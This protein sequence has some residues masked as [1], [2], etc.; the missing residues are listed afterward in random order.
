MAD[1]SWLQRVALSDD[2]SEAT[3]RA[4]RIRTITN[5]GEVGYY[6]QFTAKVTKQTGNSYTIAFSNML[7]QGYGGANSDADKMSGQMGIIIDGTRYTLQ[8]WDTTATSTSYRNG[9]W[10]SVAGLSGSKSGLTR[11]QVNSATIFV[12]NLGNTRW[13]G[14]NYMDI[15][16]TASPG[17]VMKALGS[18]VQI[19]NTKYYPVIGNGVGVDRYNIQIGSDKY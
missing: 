13:T 3:M 16:D 10:T 15:S 11:E 8:N 18:T 4:K 2:K 17:F 6:F 14:Y 12:T 1:E 5:V 7:M 9:T 19:G